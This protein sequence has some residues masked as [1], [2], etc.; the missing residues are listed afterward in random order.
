MALGPYEI[1]QAIANLA[2]AVVLGGALGWEREAHYRPAGFRTHV[3]VCIGSALFMM[4][5]LQFTRMGQDAG[6][7]AAAVPTGMGFLGAGTIIRE[8]SSIRGLTTAASLWTVAAI[9]LC[10]GYGFS[11][12]PV[13]VLAAA[14]ALATLTLLSRIEQKMPKRQYRHV[15]IRGRSVRRRIPEI[16]Q[17]LLPERVEIRSLE[18]TPTTDENVQELRLIVRLPP[19]VDTPQISEKLMELD[20]IEGL[21]WE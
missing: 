6:R 16:Q 4:V 14:A 19:G 10:A 2:L 21:M 9:G 18:V 13:A 17:K 11:M 7:I 15:V 8:G 20:Q 3:L 1:L 5:S 12:Y